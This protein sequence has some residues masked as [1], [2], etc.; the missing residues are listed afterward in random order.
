MAA[1]DWLPGVVRVESSHNGGSMVGGPPRFVWHTYEA[2]YS[3]SAERGARALVAAGNEVH[4]TFHPITG[5]VVQLLP[6]SVAG[7]GLK[8]AAGGV[9][10]NRMGSVCLQVEVI[11]RA[12]RPWTADLTGAGRAG[13]ARLIRFARLHGIPDVW[14]AGRPP[15]Y[16]PG[17]SARSA[18]VWTTRA[19]HF[20]HSQVPE[21]DHGDPG[22]L[23]VKVLF[24]T[25]PPAEDPTPPIP[26]GRPPMLV[27]TTPSNGSFAC[28]PAGDHLAYVKVDAALAARWVAGGV[29]GA[30]MSAGDAQALMHLQASVQDA[31]A[32]A[33]V[34]VR[35]L[36]AELVPLL[37]PGSGLTA[38]AVVDAIAARLAV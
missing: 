26:K 16:P 33:T 8:N 20:G 9:Q 4:F 10:T 14:P 25:E 28:W 37:P 2:P 30:S 31:P 1:S 22:A 12:A 21:N 18:A 17:D 27:I 32:Q 24:T 19:G 38:A 29:P 7:R 5:D 11:A 15:A 13:L 35:A 23:D 6:A 34:D 3:L 36:A